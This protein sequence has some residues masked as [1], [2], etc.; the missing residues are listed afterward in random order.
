MIHP[1]AIVSPQAR[2]GADVVVGPYAVVGDDDVEVGDRTRIDSHAVVQGPTCV[3]PDNHLHPFVSIGGDPQDRKFD[4]SPTRLEIG[5]RNVIREY[6]TFHRGTPGGG[7]VTRIGDDNWIMAYVHVAH[8]CRVGSNTVMANCA[9]LAGHVTVDDFVVL[10]AFTVVHQ[11]CAIGRHA[12]TA[13]GSVV[14]KDLPPYVTAGGKRRRRPRHQ[15][16]GPAA[17]GVR[18]RDDPGAAP[19]LP[20]DLRNGLRVPEALER[21]EEMREECPEVAPFIEFLAASSR[22]IVRQGRR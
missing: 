21:L 16:R 12:F 11:F 19:S 14:F 6:C 22:G 10:G 2:L 9:T 7:G 20:A 1:T 8:D 15:S 13:M 4:G 18:A 17:R 3:G 5:D